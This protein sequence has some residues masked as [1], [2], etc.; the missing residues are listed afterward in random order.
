MRP[1][2]TLLWNDNA[3]DFGLSITVNPIVSNRSLKLGNILWPKKIRFRT[4]IKDL[5]LHFK[6]TNSD[7]K[8]RTLY[9][10]E[11]ALS[12]LNKRTIPIKEDLNILDVETFGGE[13]DRF[14]KEIKD[15]FCISLLKQ[16]MSLHL[17]NLK[18]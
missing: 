10:A 15:Y 13:A 9:R 3:T 2:K 7:F 18:N 14:W 1:V 17:S 4:R 16:S 12:R 11:K 8:M 5:D 6:K